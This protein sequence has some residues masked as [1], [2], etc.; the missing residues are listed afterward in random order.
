MD[1]ELYLCH[2][3]GKIL[4]GDAFD[5]AKTRVEHLWSASVR[6]PHGP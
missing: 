2:D 1:I 4:L 5:E 3:D 6:G